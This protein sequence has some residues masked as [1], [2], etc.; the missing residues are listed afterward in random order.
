MDVR[1]SLGGCDAMHFPEA[2]PPIMKI[3]RVLL[4][5]FVTV[6]LFALAVMAADPAGTWK[7]SVSGP[8]GNKFVINCR[9]KTDGDPTKGTLELPDVG[10]GGP[11]RMEWNAR[12]V[13]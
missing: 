11:S 2:P 6:S 1:A 10:G 3:P 7:W 5:A 9:G 4:A 8:D 12:S 13:K